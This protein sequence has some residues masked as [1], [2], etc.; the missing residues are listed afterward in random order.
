[1]GSTREPGTPFGP[2]P[3]GRG[4]LGVVISDARPLRLTNIQA[5]PRS[6]GFPPNHPPMTSF[7]GVPVVAGGSVFGNLYLTEKH[8]GDFTETDERLAT[9]L[10]AQAGVRSRTRG[11][12]RRHRNTC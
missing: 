12:S 9:T 7:L 4:I 11:S 5:D 3:I 6:A 10:A 1:M 2:E 8:G